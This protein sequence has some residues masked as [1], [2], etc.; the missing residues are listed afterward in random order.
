[1]SENLVK[2]IYHIA[3]T[4]E[5]NQITVMT[6]HLKFSGVLCKLEECKIKTDDGILTLK[7][8]KMSRIEDICTCG[9]KGCKCNEDKFCFIGWLNINISKVVAFSVEPK[10]L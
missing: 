7:D 2:K 9:S 6:N 10:A 1:M 5:T 4:C 8:V 3:E